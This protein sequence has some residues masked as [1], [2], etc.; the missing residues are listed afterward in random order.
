MDLKTMEEKLH[1]Q[2]GLL[3]HIRKIVERENTLIGDKLWLILAEKIDETK[4]I[5]REILID[6]F[7]D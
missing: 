3:E 1:E 2:L 6:H 5:T 4:E 7:S